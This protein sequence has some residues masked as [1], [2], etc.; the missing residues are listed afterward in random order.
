MGVRQERDGTIASQLNEGGNAREV[1]R[2]GILCRRSGELLRIVVLYKTRE[3]LVLKL[4]GCVIYHNIDHIC[5][6]A[7]IGDEREFLLN[8]RNLIRHR[9]ITISMQFD[10]QDLAGRMTWLDHEWLG[11]F[12]L[13]EGTPEAEA[14]SMRLIGNA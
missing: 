7:I 13:K 3:R 5:S 10:E 9:V 6:R 14:G 4:K 8:L 11:L 2:F 12:H 1:G